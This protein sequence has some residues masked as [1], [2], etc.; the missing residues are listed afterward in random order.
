MDVPKRSDSPLGGM[1]RKLGRQEAERE[2]RKRT[3]SLDRV[4]EAFERRSRSLNRT[5]R[6]WRKEAHLGPS[7]LPAFRLSAEVRGA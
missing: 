6:S 1:R 2:Q 4:A 5:N 3:R 7:A